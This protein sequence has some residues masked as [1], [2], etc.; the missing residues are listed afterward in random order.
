M[1]RGS[2][3]ELG[4]LYRAA[5]IQNLKTC[6]HAERGCQADGSLCTCDT[7]RV[8]QWQI[9]VTTQAIGRSM[10]AH[11]WDCSGMG[12][13]PPRIIRARHRLTSLKDF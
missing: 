7:E 1:T 8:S 13:H 2:T 4:S 9:S 11:T 10:C 12:S 5:V 3:R 6:P